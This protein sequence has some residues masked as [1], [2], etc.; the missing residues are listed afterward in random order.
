MLNCNE[1][2]LNGSVDEA[3]MNQQELYDIFA[4]SRAR[5]LT[6]FEN[7]LG[8]DVPSQAKEVHIG[9]WTQFVDSWMYSTVLTT[10]PSLL[11]DIWYLTIC[12]YIV[13]FQLFE[14]TNST[15]ETIWIQNSKRVLF[16]VFIFENIHTNGFETRKLISWE[17]QRRQRRFSSL[18]C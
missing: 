1:L 15:S 7:T 16:D 12:I 5:R 3:C 4:M 18:H 6:W 14:N 2:I 8:I 17:R 10:A 11:F 13:L 9:T